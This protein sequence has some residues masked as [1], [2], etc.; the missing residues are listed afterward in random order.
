[1]ASATSG[2]AAEVPDDDTSKFGDWFKSEQGQVM[3]GG[4]FN[5][6]S[7][8]GAGM[9]GLPAGGTDM[10]S[11]GRG[12]AA[13]TQGFDI[14]QSQYDAK[15][16][17]RFVDG[18]IAEEMGKAESERS[19]EKLQ[20]LQMMRRDPEGYIKA[21]GTKEDWFEKMVAMESFREGR[22]SAAYAVG[23]QAA[24]RHFDKVLTA[25]AREKLLSGDPTSLQFYA[26]QHPDMVMYWVG[27]GGKLENAFPG[28][29]DPEKDIEGWRAWVKSWFSSDSKDGAD[30]KPTGYTP[31]PAPTPEKAATE[32]GR[33]A[34]KYAEENPESIDLLRSILNPTTE[35]LDA[36]IPPGSMREESRP[37]VEQ[38]TRHGEFLRRFIQKAWD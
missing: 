29:P 35:Q 4:L 3:V 5:A 34:D 14:A 13:A 27:K 15:T 21:E 8:L 6:I 23:K 37:L 30:D 11:L 20:T 7:S 16:F 9:A 25:E 1:M 17:R 12:A 26:I 36:L 10:S 24:D 33:A 2:S 28:A 18:K 38:G 22:I 19:E 31:P 32:G